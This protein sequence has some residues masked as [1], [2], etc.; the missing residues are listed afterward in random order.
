LALI[1]AYADA[2]EPSPR[3]RTLLPSL[4]MGT[5]RKDFK[6]FDVLL[7]VLERDGWVKVERAARHENKP[8]RYELRLGAEDRMVTPYRPLVSNVP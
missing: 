8:N 7:A 6:H 5:S 4:G 1:A 3:A 2:G